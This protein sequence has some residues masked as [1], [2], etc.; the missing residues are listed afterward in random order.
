MDATSKI[1]A[2]FLGQFDLA[3]IPIMPNP[4]HLTKSF[5]SP[6]YIFLFTNKQNPAASS[7]A[8][9]N[10]VPA[11]PH[12]QQ[13]TSAPTTAIHGTAAAIPVAMEAV[14]TATLAIEGAISIM[15]HHQR[16]TTLVAKLLIPRVI[17]RGVVV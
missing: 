10:P 16:D 11:P 7:S 2:A 15:A 5:D 8:A 3:L 1:C 9:V 13:P 14:T 4:H 12:A 6:S 17:G